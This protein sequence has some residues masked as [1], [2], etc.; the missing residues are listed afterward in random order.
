L[1][2][3]CS[4]PVFTAFATSP[5][6][7]PRVGQVR[8]SSHTTI[9]YLV[10]HP[11]R[12]KQQLIKAFRRE[13][14]TMEEGLWGGRIPEI[15][16]GR[17]RWLWRRGCRRS[18]SPVFSTMLL[19]VQHRLLQFFLVIRKQSMNLAMRLVADSVDL[20]TELLARSCRIL[21]EQRLNL[22]VVLVKQGPDLLLLFRSQ[23]QIFRKPSKFLVDRLRRMDMLKLLT[24]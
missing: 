23:L 6:L 21:I 9:L 13:R 8:S 7:F 18:R 12:D 3:R 24:G 17:M 16:S 22:I 11:A 5:D 4:L 14:L 2:I 15:S 19:A 1:A 10:D 20:G